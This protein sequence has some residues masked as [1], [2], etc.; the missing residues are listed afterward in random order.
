MAH[1][2]KWNG[3]RWRARWRDPDGR[4]QSKIFDRKLDAENFLKRIEVAKLEGSYVDPKAGR[5]SFAEYARQW[6]AAQ[7]HRASTAASVQSI[8]DTHII[9]RFGDRTIASIR[10]SEVQA[11]VAGLELA[12]STAGVVYGKL[13]AIFNAATADRIIVRSPCVRIR[14]PRSEGAEVVPMSPEQVA[15]MAERVGDRYGAFVVL[16]AGSGLRPAEGLGLTVDRVNFLKR[17]LRIDRQLVTVAKK[18]P[19]LA[20]P[21]TPTSVRTIPVPQAVLDA[22]ALQIERF[23][24]GPDGLIFTDAKGDPIRRSALGH[25]WRRAAAK[26]GLLGFTPHDLRHYAASVLIDSGASVKAVQR[27]LGHKSAKTTLDVYGHLWPES[28]D[29]TRKA[30][31]SGLA[32]IVPGHSGVTD[33]S[34]I[35][36]S[37]V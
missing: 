23:G 7:P 1:V 33:G 31:E 8:L 11:W 16:L 2:T 3:G 26:V 5:Q 14:L 19:A 13:A 15:T 12:P 35:Q 27:H 22:L 34:R 17:S 32:A 21:K 20:P 25:Q 29:V 9:P 37:G 4:T 30:L 6:A 10:T 18:A 24:T 28:E 36:A